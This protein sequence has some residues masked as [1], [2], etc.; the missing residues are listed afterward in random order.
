MQLRIA[1]NSFHSVP[2]VHNDGPSAGIC[3]IVVCYQ[4]N[5]VC[6]TLGL[7]QCADFWLFDINGCS[8]VC[9]LGIKPMRVVFLDRM[10][11]TGLGLGL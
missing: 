5:D 6:L 3:R 4:F 11:A 1:F 8:L 2:S 9:R 10:A 7:V